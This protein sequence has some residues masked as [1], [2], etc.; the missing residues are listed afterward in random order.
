[1]NIVYAIKSPLPLWKWVQP[2]IYHA[3]SIQ[4]IQT[5]QPVQQ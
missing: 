4:T 1:M 3:S 2:L 5:R